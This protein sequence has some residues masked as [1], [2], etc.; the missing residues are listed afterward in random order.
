[1]QIP[2]PLQ[3]TAAM[4]V[5]EPQL[6]QS[7]PG[8]KYLLL[9]LVFLV[10]SFGCKQ[11][12]GKEPDKETEYTYQSINDYDIPLLPSPAE[13]LGY[14]RSS[15]ADGQEQRSA[16]KAVGLFHPDDRYHA[17]LASLELAYLTL[18]P[19]YR[20]AERQQYR[21]AIQSYLGILDIFPD[22]PEINAKAL[23]YLGWI[24]CDLLR[25]KT[26]GISFYQRIVRHYP[27]ERLSLLPPAPW[28]SIHFSDS[29]QGHQ[30]YYP[31]SSLLWSDIARLEIIRHSSDFNEADNS[32]TALHQTHGHT[33]ILFLALKLMVQ[34]HGLNNKI[35]VQA[36]QFLGDGDVP[37]FQKDDLRLILSTLGKR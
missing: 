3:Q 15:F 8:R 31:K 28:L 16:L 26:Q 32:F 19:D 37:S 7:A 5:K 17:G 14:A 10:L 22:Q 24:Y 11:P 4:T 34:N 20:L 2:C 18:G 35:L 36:K 6:P 25:E 21:Q 30:P 27:K 12:T 13:Q 1:M 29:E 33:P 23:W 9:L